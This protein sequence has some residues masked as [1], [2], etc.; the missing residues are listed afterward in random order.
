MG[1]QS[2]TQGV[3]IRFSVVAIFTLSTT[4]LA[5]LAIGLH[6][7]FG[8][9][10]AKDAAG[11]LYANVAQAAAEEI[12]SFGDTTADIA[13]LLAI[14]PEVAAAGSGASQLRLFAMTLS[15]HPAF[16]VLD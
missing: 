10:L 6:Y 15:Q 16:F 5:A 13:E 1:L 2:A 3:S 7:Y 11:Q 8:S 9:G 12:V 4:L 14:Y